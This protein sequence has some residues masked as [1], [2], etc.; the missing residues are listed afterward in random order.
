MQPITALIVGQIRNQQ[1]LFRSIANLLAARRDGLVDRIVVATWTQEKAKI[2]E[3]LPAFEAAGVLVSAVDEPAA[4]ALAPGNL[5]NQMRGVDLAL[6]TV[7]DSAWV[8]RARP[9][10]MIEPGMIA[11]L[12]GADMR[13]AAPGPAGAPAHKIW[14]PFAELCQPMC[15]S[16]IAFFGQYADFVKLQNFDFFHEVA[17][18]HLDT[19]PGAR[20]ITSYDAEIR[21]FTPAFVAAY[22]VLQ[23]FYRLSNRFLLGIHELRR[24][25]LGFLWSQDLYWQY[26]ATYFDILERYFLIGRDV[27][28][29]PLRL[30]RADA[31][32]QTDLLG[33]VDLSR[34][35][36]TREALARE[37]DA[38]QT[39]AL[40]AEAPAYCADSAGIA[41]FRRHLAA[42]GMPLARALGDARAYRKD[43][44]RIEA[45]RIFRMRLHVAMLGGVEP[46]R[47]KAEAWHRPFAT[48]FISFSKV[49]PAP[50]PLARSA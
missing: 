16:D 9:D 50:P 47:P 4:N 24:A 30:V 6:E 19:G 32:E 2:A 25:M 43:A 13:L 48:D 38:A 34:C 26:A 18:T 37:P 33:C 28:E 14:A 3:M 5:V 45:Q 8:L 11:S 21:R 29:G 23:E 42:I 44:A 31:F 49:D 39:C 10:L 22:P 27:V 15:I 46:R 17:G 35:A 36:Y 41:A 1:V 7:E 40:F 20:L 12:A